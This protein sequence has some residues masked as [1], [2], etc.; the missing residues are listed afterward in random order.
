MSRH[1]FAD[2][3]SGMDWLTWRINRLRCMSPAEIPHRLMRAVSAGVESAALLFGPPRVPAPDLAA[4][5]KPWIHRNASV[6]AAP[7]TAA[8]GR[9]AAGRLDVFALRNAELGSPPRW[10]QDPKSRIV[11]PPGFGKH[12]DYRDARLVGDIKYLW[13]PNR[14]LHL[15]TLAQAY[16]LSGDAAHLEVMRLHLESWFS[17]CPCR[18]GPNW[19][20][21]LEAAIRLVNWSAAWQLAGC[22]PGAERTLLAS[23]RNLWLQLRQ[24][25]SP[26]AASG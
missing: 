16:A 4:Q 21:A 23:A 2:A 19:S 25:A 1:E 26:P 14:H 15:V 13:E 8:A 11:S 22:P 5:S 24:R 20:S 7:Y 17:A 6:D 18:M 10:D 3:G 12:L 9:V